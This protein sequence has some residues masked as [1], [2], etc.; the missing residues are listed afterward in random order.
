[1]SRTLPTTH[2]IS[3]PIISHDLTEWGGGAATHNSGCRGVTIDDAR[4]LAADLARHGTAGGRRTEQ[5]DGM[6][7]RH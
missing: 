1:M 2:P 4:G 6:V 7:L 5:R 3:S